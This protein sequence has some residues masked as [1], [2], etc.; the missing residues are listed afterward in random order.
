MNTGSEDKCT[1]PDC[2]CSPLDAGK[3]RERCGK[4]QI[5]QDE[6]YLQKLRDAHPMKQLKAERDKY[7]KALE[8]ICQ[9]GRCPIAEK[10]L[11]I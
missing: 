4:A 9:R 8:Q 5:A 6:D 2:T 11:G 10:A 7:R 3:P 1:Y